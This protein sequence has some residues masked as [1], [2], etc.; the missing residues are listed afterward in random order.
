LNLSCADKL[1]DNIS[2]SEKL[3]GQAQDFAEI[4]ETTSKRLAG[5][6]NLLLVQ[7]RLKIIDHPEFQTLAG[8][9][10]SYAEY[11]KEDAKQ[12]RS[13]IPLRMSSRLATG[14]LFAI[15][16]GSTG[17][18]HYPQIALLM[19][20][21]YEMQ[22]TPKSIQPASIAR[23]ANRFRKSERDMYDLLRDSARKHKLERHST[24]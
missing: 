18:P 3:A 16:E 10:K 11:L 14:Y 19:E 15:V 21:Y 1:Q 8:K 22:G 5:V 6:E 20:A 17:E 12:L 7:P 9:M 23:T 13:G 24:P 4:L 2:D